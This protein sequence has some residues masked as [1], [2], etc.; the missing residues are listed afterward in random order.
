MLFSRKVATLHAETQKLADSFHGRA[1]VTRATG[2]ID[3]HSWEMT[4]VGTARVS[5]SVFRKHE[6]DDK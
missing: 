2:C 3:D 6:L 5:V 4:E 1:A